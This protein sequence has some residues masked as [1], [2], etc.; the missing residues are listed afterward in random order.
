MKRR[1]E[2]QIEG[3]ACVKFLRQ[4]ENVEFEKTPHSQC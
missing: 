4:R 2:F 1:R 3:I